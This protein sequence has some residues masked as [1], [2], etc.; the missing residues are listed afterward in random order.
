MGTSVDHLGFRVPD[1]QAT[2]TKLKGVQT[3]WKNANWGWKV[4]SGTRPGQAFATTPAGTMVELLEDKTL[5]VPITFDHTHFYAEES[6][7]KEMESVYTKLFGAKP[8][9][10]ETDTLIIP[11]GKL[12]FSKSATPPQPTKGHSL[13]HIG[14]NML[15][16]EALKAF[17]K[18]LEEKG[19]KFDRP[20]ENSS[21]GM[22]SVFDGFG[23]RIEITKAQGGYFDPKLLDAAF[24]QVDEGGRKEGDPPRQR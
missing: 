20:Y 2:T 16:A 10:G 5:K 19:A 23:T 21:M 12:V 6:H 18:A 8:V 22:T 9:R 4:E 11:G 1:L 24:Y 7:L 14:F 3:W 17:S 15:N 13:D